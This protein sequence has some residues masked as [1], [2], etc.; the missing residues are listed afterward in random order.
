MCGWLSLYLR[1]YWC[2]LLDARRMRHYARAR[3]TERD[4]W[5]NPSPVTSA[6]PAEA[7]QLVRDSGA[8][9]SDTT[10]AGGCASTSTGVSHVQSRGAP[11]VSSTL[12]HVAGL[13]PATH[14]LAA[15]V[16]FSCCPVTRAAS[17]TSQ[18]RALT[19]VSRHSST[20][21]VVGSPGRSTRKGGQ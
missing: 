15:R 4:R 8:R 12:S 2:A 9:R 19:S 5:G 20:A 11:C 16:Y 6:P 3:L 13:G 21:G 10:G 1:S 18:T 17:T 14:G 7:Y